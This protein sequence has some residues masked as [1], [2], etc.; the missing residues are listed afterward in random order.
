MHGDGLGADVP[1]PGVGS[2]RCAGLSRPAGGFEEPL[3]AGRWRDFLCQGII[4]AFEQI[5]GTKKHIVRPWNRDAFDHGCNQPC[6]A[7]LASTSIP[8]ITGCR[9]RAMAANAV[10]NPFGISTETLSAA[11]SRSLWSQVPRKSSNR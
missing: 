11:A 3:C 7:V 8:T 9:S 1:L 6:V 5:N 2:G 4:R 10:A